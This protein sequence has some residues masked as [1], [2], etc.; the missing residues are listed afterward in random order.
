MN[1]PLASPTLM[2]KECEIGE[3]VGMNTDLAENEINARIAEYYVPYHLGLGQAAETFESN[4]IISIHSFTK[5]Y[6]NQ[7]R[8]V[9]IGILSSTKD[10]LAETL[11]QGLIGNGYPKSEINAPWSGKDGFMYAADSLAFSGQSK[12]ARSDFDP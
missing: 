10:Q 7:E 2:R 3:F 5:V 1:R 8:S 12:F 4:L 6:Q 11:L 9:E